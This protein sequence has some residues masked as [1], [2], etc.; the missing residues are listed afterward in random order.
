MPSPQP[1][2]VW[3]RDDLRLSDHPALHA[4]AK[5]GAPVVCLYVLDDAAGR[6]PGGA[7]RWWLAQSLRA[8]GADIAT[9]GGSLILRKGP[10]AKVIPEVV[11]ES[12]AAA[13]YWNGIAQ[14]SHQ[15]VEKALEAALA[16]LGASSQI[17]PGDLLVAPSEIRNKE[18][19]G[20]R[21]FTPFW[22]RVLSLG[23]P[24]KPLP[25]PKVLQAGPNIPGDTLESWKLEP[26]KPDWAGGLRERWTP[27][28]ASARTGL[29]D[30][31]KHTVRSYAADRDRPDRDCTSGLS[32]HLR[33]GE[34]SPRQVWHAARFAAAE[35]HA[36]GPGVDKFLSEL[37]WREFCRHLLHDHPDLATENLQANFDGFPWKPDDAA[38]AAWQRGRT[39]Y[40]IV[41]AGLRELWHT[42]VMH[43]RVRMVVASFLVK[44]LLIDWRDGESWFW[45]TLVDADAG[46][47]PA[48]WQ[49]V[50]G[51][52][53]D[54][55][56]YFRVFNPQLQGE[57]FDPDGSYVRR[58]VPELKDMP[59]KLI[60]QPWQATPLELASA[61]VTLGKTYPQ[62]I[63]DHAK[64]RER[65]LAAYAKIRKG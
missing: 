62:P 43:N 55:A 2:I 34:L 61:G 40:P 38:L 57:K 47:N 3:F 46:S 41:D 23:D 33:F 4:A 19:R 48:N 59:A 9:R 6:A 22:R 42:G 45:D 35:D 8:L 50:A 39:G 63:V 44:H 53:A 65:A 15:A 16:K 14:A 58:W 60:H 51:C 5:S 24:P 27:G 10:A 17:F 29:R 56:P 49:W 32:P 54:A 11:R 25:A 18:G 7:A 30:F 28:E 52:G 31:L 13:V 36:T 37:G 64:G 20:L 12:G 21:V 26:G 1:I